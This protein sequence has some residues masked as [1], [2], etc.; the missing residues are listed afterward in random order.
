GL[1]DDIENC[2]AGAFFRVAADKREIATALASSQADSADASSREIELRSGLLED[3]NRITAIDPGKKAASLDL[4]PSAART[5]A[6][7]SSGDF[8]RSSSAENVGDAQNNCWYGEG[9]GY[10]IDVDAY[11]GR[12][13]YAMENV[14]IG[15]YAGFWTDGGDN[16][17]TDLLS[18]KGDAN[19]FIGFECGLSNTV[20]YQNAFLGHSAGYSNING[21]HNT[22]VGHRAGYHNQSGSGNCYIGGAAGEDTSSGNHNTC[23][24]YNAGNN[25]STESSN[26][27]IGYAAGISNSA[28]ANVFVG[29]S[30]GAFNNTGSGNTFIGTDA[31]SQNISG[32][33][34]VYLGNSSGFSATGNHNTFVGFQSGYQATAGADNTLIGQKA[35][36]SMTD[37]NHNTFLGNEAGYSCANGNGNTCIG[38]WSGYS[39]TGS[40]NVFIGYMA[41]L[42]ETGSNKLYISNG[43]WNL[44]EGDFSAKTLQ[45]NGNI[46][47]DQAYASSDRRWKSAI[48]SIEEPIALVEKLHGV[49]YL[50]NREAYP[51]KGFDE[52]RQLGLIAQEVEKILPEMVKTDA[53][54]YKSVAYTQLLP[55]LIEAIKAQQQRIMLQQQSQD[56]LQAQIDELR[57]LISGDNRI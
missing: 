16:P 50:W 11:D 49:S 9:A 8:P 57:R 54:G 47:F 38:D 31:G 44:V 53:S 30:A 56:G 42:L 18:D 14:F 2:A 3:G 39:A 35:G 6:V 13:N 23:L 20:G 7:A 46:E 55:L 43:N 25:I 4:S 36:Y 24:G 10:E 37:G 33:R 32:F 5:A 15:A 21:N 52:R 51:E 19:C 27:C 22:F 28:D 45:I 40:N 48:K 26:V 1:S 41:G 12:N 17:G 29:A 34:N